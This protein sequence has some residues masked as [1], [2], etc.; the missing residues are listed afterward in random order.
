MLIVRSPNDYSG[1]LAPMDPREGDQPAQ[2]A[3]PAQTGWIRRMAPFLRPQARDLVMVFGAALL[4]MVAT[5][6]APLVMRRIVD[7]AILHDRAAIGPLLAA[8]VG[9]G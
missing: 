3:Q 4:G 5:A 6:I 8:L 2:P 9:L 1:I 7:D